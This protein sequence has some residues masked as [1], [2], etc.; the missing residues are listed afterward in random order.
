[1]QRIGEGGFAR[2]FKAV[3]DRREV[4]VKISINLDRETGRSFT[5]EI[6]S[7]SMLEHEN[8][9]RLY[10]S[11]ILPVPYLEMELCE[12]SLEEKDKPM[13]VEEASR[14]IFEIAK[15]LK[16]AHKKGIIHRDLKPSNILFNNGNAKISDWGLSKLKVGSKSSS[17]TAFSPL[18][19]APEHFSKTKFGK[20]DER[21]DLYQLGVVFYELVTGELPLK[22]EDVAG[23][24]FSIINDQP[25]PVSKIKVESRQVE[26]I[27]MKCL[28]K[29]KEERYQSV[30]MFLEDLAVYLKEEY[31]KSRHFRK[32]AF[33]L[34]ELLLRSVE[35]GDTSEAVGWATEGL[36]S[37]PKRKYS[38]KDVQML[39]NSVKVLMD[40]KNN[41]CNENTKV[42]EV[43]RR[44][45]ELKD[46]LVEE[47]FV[48]K[49]ETDKDLGMVIKEVNADLREDEYLAEKHVGNLEYFC[50]KFTERWIARFLR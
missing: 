49:I 40:I 4:A 32:S 45:N 11:N 37:Y 46:N 28:A 10:D 27:I 21:T 9:V 39:K 36:V 16:H 44:Y 8:I 12:C 26:H 14:T 22:G 1:M 23:I 34:Y 24:S 15:G 35:R 17:V 5:K 18:Y 2:V 41:C 43:N 29:R 38:E 6:M 30:D 33:Y 19:A 50:V 13:Q 42:K 3:R 47:D 7:W 48:G 20:T 31:K 25:V